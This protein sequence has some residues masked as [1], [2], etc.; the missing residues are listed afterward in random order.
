MH[1]LQNFAR[2]IQEYFLENPSRAAIFVPILLGE[3]E[4][5]YNLD[6]LQSISSPE[7]AHE[8][9][10]IRGF[11]EQNF[12][13]LTV[14]SPDKTCGHCKPCMEDKSHI[15]LHGRLM[16]ALAATRDTETLTNLSFVLVVIIIHSLAHAFTGGN[17]MPMSKDGF[18]FYKSHYLLL[19]K[20]IAEPG[21]FAE[22]GIFGG[23]IGIVFK[24]QEN[25][26]PP[27]FLE[28]DFTRIAYLFILD[29]T[30]AAYRL[31]TGELAEQLRRNRFGRFKNSLR[32]EVPRKITERTCA[33]FNEAILQHGNLWYTD[34]GFHP[35]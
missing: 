2:T 26:M 31:D 9:G 30:G 21:F 4:E 28:A 25:G 34:P 10:A 7:Y 20:S 5:N 6:N 11:I 13:S 24:D 33:A 22:E 27:K 35:E 17:P 18:P 3:A 19:N 1:I 29:R 23:I 8:L 15:E 12:P 32:V 14:S 16:D